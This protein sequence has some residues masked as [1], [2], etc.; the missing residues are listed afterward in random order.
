M[1]QFQGEQYT[2]E[3]LKYIYSALMMIQVSGGDA[4]MLVDLQD[5][6]KNIIQMGEAK[7][8]KPSTPPGKRN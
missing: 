8:E 6:T 3:E 7:I 4:R 2:I 1:L 5:K